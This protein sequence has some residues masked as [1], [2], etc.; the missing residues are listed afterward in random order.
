M[1]GIYQLTGVV[2]QYDWGGYDYIPSLLQTV[3]KPKKPFA[4]YWM[5]VHPLGTA[6]LD[7]GGSTPTPLN[8]LAPGLSFLLKVL[9]VRD[10]LS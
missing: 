3:N 4:E 9:D 2:K 10:M 8:F 5:G 6:G 7:T 1:P